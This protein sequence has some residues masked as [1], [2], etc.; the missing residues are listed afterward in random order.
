MNGFGNWLRQLGYKIS[1]GFRQFMVGR[2]GND[3]LNMWILGGGVILCLISMF[4]SR[5]LVNLLLTVLSYVCM[6]TAIFRTFSRNT[7]KRY[8]ENRK[9]LLLLDKIKDREHKY[10]SCPK[11]RQSVRV[12]RGKGKIAITCPKCRE[13]F[14]RKS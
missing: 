10:F 12:P 11:C 13:K 1:N 8:Q 4:F 6:F 7:Y 5:P 9:F 3:K 14:I 2:Y